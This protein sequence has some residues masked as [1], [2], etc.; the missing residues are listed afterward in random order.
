M[1]KNA[2][3]M[4]EKTENSLGKKPRTDSLPGVEEVFTTEINQNIFSSTF[5]LSRTNIGGSELLQDL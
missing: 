1:D 4:S 3:A 2:T 5:D